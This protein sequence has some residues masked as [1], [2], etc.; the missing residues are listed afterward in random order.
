M[1]FVFMGKL[2]FG[3]LS[4]RRTTD[5]AIDRERRPEENKNDFSHL[6]RAIKKVHR[7]VDSS[8]RRSSSVWKPK[9]T[10]KTTER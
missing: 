1:S 9:P 6:E 10:P 4:P 7:L 8:L 3:V 2:L 5:D